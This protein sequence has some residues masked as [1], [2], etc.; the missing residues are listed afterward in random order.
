MSDILF[1]VRHLSKVFDLGRGVGAPRDQKRLLYAVE[2][3]NFTMKKGETLGVVGESGSGK[4]TMGRCLVGLEKP[5][6]GSITYRGQDLAKI[7]KQQQQKLRKDMQIVFQNPIS[8]FNPSKTVGESLREVAA[9]HGLSKTQ[10]NDRIGNLL[11]FVHLDSEVLQARSNVLSGGQLQRLAIVRALI[12][13]PSFILAD[14]PVSALDVS[15]QAQILRLFDNLKRELGVSTL[16]VSHD[17]T[18]VEHLCDRVIVM[19]LGSIVEM[20]PVR[21]LFDHPLHPYTQLLLAS[22]PREFPG[23]VV[24]RFEPKGEIT[25]AIG[26]AHD[27]RFHSRC[28][29]SVNGVC[30]QEIPSLLEVSPGHWVACVLSDKRR[31]IGKSFRL[32][33]GIWERKG[34][35]VG[36]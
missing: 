11:G 29:V 16:F 26:R 25:S 36:A 7:P 22:R 6:Q 31:D 28:P 10:S 1:D 23:Q 2:D 21:K 19:Y 13:N 24:Q 35:Q 15:V 34:M 3:M 9:F 33:H 20:A 27:C 14:E 4:S 5:T 32:T 30:D 12:P 17:L 18:V 8:S